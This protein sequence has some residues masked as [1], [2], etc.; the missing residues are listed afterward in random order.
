MARSVLPLVGNSSGNS[1]RDTDICMSGKPT[2]PNIAKPERADS[3]SSPEVRRWREPARQAPLPP[4][5]GGGDGGDALSGMDRR[6]G[7]FS[8][9]GWI[10]VLISC[11][12]HLSMIL[13]LSI[14][15]VFGPRANRRS[16]VVTSEFSD[17]ALPRE[18]DASPVIVS[19][20]ATSES[21]V[22]Q[23]SLEGTSDLDLPLEELLRGHGPARRRAS[24]LT[25]MSPADALRRGSMRARG[26]GFEA[27]QG[28]LKARM[29]AAGGGTPETERA[30]QQGLAWLAAHQW[31]DGGWRFDF[32]DGPCSGR[33]RNSGTV[34]TS[35]GATGL[36]LLPFLG[37]GHTHQSGK[38]RHV[39]QNGLEYLK[40][41]I[42]QTPEGADL[43]E[44]TMY[45]QGIA[46]IAFCEAYA[47]TQDATLGPSAQ[48]AIDFIDS[49][50]HSEGGWRYYP[51][52]PGDTTVF[53]WQMMALKSAELGGLNVPAPTVT[54]GKHFLD[55]VQLA[56]G[57]YYGYVRPDKDPGP[58]AIGLLIRMYMGWDRN[59]PRLVEGVD[60]LAALGPSPHD[61]YFDYYATQVLHHYGGAQWSTWN[62][63]MREH[64]LETQATR[65]H[66]RG[67]WFFV[68][69][70]GSKG[71]RLYTTAMCVMILE[72]YYRHMPLYEERAV[73]DHLW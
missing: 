71:G 41:R 43:Q 17:D 30:V 68:D 2:V 1:L 64:L 51:G 6:R 63:S 10:S 23:R 16:L 67:S 21:S 36:A 50:Q 5:E 56:S 53:G 42:A 9:R 62:E 45:A 13:V 25:E 22:A 11:G 49:A 31:Q 34:A 4:E 60:Y 38:Y 26:G 33:C 66:E 48:A 14:L 18:L 8:L 52:Q 32:S 72:V 28:E 55:S 27:R 59:D 29:L 44:G 24:Q 37:A 73:N 39:V 40:S 70:H 47:M 12:F 7:L 61:V 3:A 54:R 46:T 58:T 65:G 20:A 35:T 15:V 69:E 19:D 57:A